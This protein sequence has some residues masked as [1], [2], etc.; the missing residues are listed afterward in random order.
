M[1][2][3]TSSPWLAGSCA[4]LGQRAVEHVDGDVGDRPEPAAEDQD[5]PL[6]ER[7]GRLDDLAVGREHGRLGEPAVDQFQAHQAVVDLGEGRA[8]ELDQVDLDPLV[9]EVV[10]Q[11]PDQLR[12]RRPRRARRG[13]G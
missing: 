7:L 11:V 5:R 8:G 3:R 10:E 2:T 1:T 13:S 4:E 9:G 12:R 6:V